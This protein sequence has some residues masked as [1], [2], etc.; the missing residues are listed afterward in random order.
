MPSAL[1]TPVVA[2]SPNPIGSLTASSKLLPEDADW[3][4]LGIQHDPELCQQAWV[5]QKCSVVVP[6]GDPEE[7]DVVAKPLNEGIEAVEFQP[8]LIEAN[9]ASCEGLLGRLELLDP[10]ARRTLQWNASRQLARAFSH[11]FPDGYANV[12]P[13]LTNTA[14]DITDAGPSSLTNT[15]QDLLKRAIDCG[16]T[17]DLTIH[18]P[19]WTLPRF[20]EEYLIEQV[21]STFKM[22][23]HT[24]VL[25]Y[26][27]PNIGPIGSADAEADEAWIYVTGPVEYAL[28]RV[29]VPEQA[30]QGIAIRL[31]DKDVL[32]MQL[33]IFR[34]DPCCV[35]AARARICK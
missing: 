31:N 29:F 6:D 1:T 17:G 4:A 22:G 35:F 10:R 25:D 19:A 26:G 24:V 11:P 15:I 28:D 9:A 3:Q 18:A 14:T 23:P 21:G 8:F 30:A 34:F 20:L 5:W 2:G 16:A 27:Y 12:N 33:A 13:N 7:G 32:A